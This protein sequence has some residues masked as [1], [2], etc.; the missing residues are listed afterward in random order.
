MT[1]NIF[2]LKGELNGEN[3]SGVFLFFVGFIADNSKKLVHIF[4]LQYSTSADPEGGTW[5]LDPPPWKITSYMGS[6]R[7]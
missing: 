7:E 1:I 2:V 5:G 4:I 6:Y 3:H